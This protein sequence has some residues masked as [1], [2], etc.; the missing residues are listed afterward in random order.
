MYALRPSEKGSLGYRG[1][2]FIHGLE[3]FKGELKTIRLPLLSVFHTLHAINN[4]LSCHFALLVLVFTAALG[5]TA[6]V[7]AAVVVFV[8]ALL[9]TELLFA[10]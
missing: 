3:C 1:V 10:S 7:V 6:V 4:V 2:N 9:E 8:G 5:A